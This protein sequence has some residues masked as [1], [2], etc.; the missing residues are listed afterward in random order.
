M[1]HNSLYTEKR[2]SSLFIGSASILQQLLQFPK[3]LHMSEFFRIDSW[4]QPDPA[5]LCVS[6]HGFFIQVSEKIIHA[7]DRTFLLSPAPTHSP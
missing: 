2:E 1:S 6:I 4:S 3:T 5:L 7:F